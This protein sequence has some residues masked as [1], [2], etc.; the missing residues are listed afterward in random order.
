[1][2]IRRVYTAAAMCRITYL[3]KCIVQN[4]HYRGEPPSDLTVPVQKLPNVTHVPNF[5]VTETEF[6]DNERSIQN[7]D[8]NDHSQNQSRDKTEDCVRVRK[9]HDGQTNVLGKEKSSSLREND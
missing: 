9:R 3:D 6:P 5:R 4:E 2:R 7:H 8:G 1:M